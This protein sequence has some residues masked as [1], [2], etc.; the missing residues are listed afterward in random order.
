MQLSCLQLDYSQE[1]ANDAS[2]G[3]NALHIQLLMQFDGYD[4][5][6]E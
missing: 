6:N 1:L 2:V 3:Q 4:K 5:T